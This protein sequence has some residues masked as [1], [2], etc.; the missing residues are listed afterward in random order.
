[1]ED[2]FEKTKVTVDGEKFAQ[3]VKDYMQ[4]YVDEVKDTILDALPDMKKLTSDIHRDSEMLQTDENGEP[5]LQFESPY[6][7]DK[8]YPEL[9]DQ[10]ILE[11]EHDD[12]DDEYVSETKANR[13]S[14]DEALDFNKQWGID[15]LTE[16][17]EDGMKLVV[18]EGAVNE[19]AQR[20]QVLFAEVSTAAKKTKV[21]E[22]EV[23]QLKSK[24]EFEAES[25]A[26]ADKEKKESKSE[27][28]LSEQD[29]AQFLTK[30]GISETTG[31][32]RDF[33]HLT[34]DQI[35]QWEAKSLPEREEADKVLLS[36]T[37]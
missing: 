25:G 24:L 23:N 28:L 7:M 13:V 37:K 33:K 35:K 20:E 11:I 26:G 36:I 4:P 10:I 29:W 9:R 1:M 30:K 5:V 32:A 27:G 2:A 16:L 31:V 8:Y 15:S 22:T 12:W 34:N 21:L 18:G 19:K 17:E 14:T 3:S 6:F